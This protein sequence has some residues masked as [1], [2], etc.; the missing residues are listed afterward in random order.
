[1]AS[2]CILKK[3]KIHFIRFNELLDISRLFLIELFL[4]TRT[5]SM[6][7]AIKSTII[8]TGNLLNSMCFLFSFFFH[9]FDH[10]DRDGGSVIGVITTARVLYS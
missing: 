1:M 8:V 10:G 6:H 3:K 9:D 2:V 4:K 7:R 5:E